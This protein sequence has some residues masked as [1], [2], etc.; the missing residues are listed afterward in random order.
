MV[1]IEDP[2]QTCPTFESDHFRFRLVG[3]DDAED[4][5]ECYSDPKAARLFNSDN[6]TSD[7]LYTTIDEVSRC[8]QFWLAEYE[9]RYYVRFSIVYKGIAK[10]VGTLE[11]FARPESTQYGKVGMLRIDLASNYEQE[12]LIGEIL[13]M[14]DQYFFQTFE[15]DSIMT[16]AIPEARIRRLSLVR[17]EYYPVEPKT[18][19]PSD[20]Y[21]I[22]TFS[23]G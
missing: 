10:V 20:H 1:H 9:Q 7:F 5:L 8:V 6:C 11:M 13:T 23:G 2:Y 3:E 4:L 21:F 14:V 16:K 22:R 17:A 19:V 18:I 12:S 15:V